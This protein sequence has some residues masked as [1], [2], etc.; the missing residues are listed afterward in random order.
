[1]TLRHFSKKEDKELWLKRRIELLKGIE[2]K[3]IIEMMKKQ[4][5]FSKKSYWYDCR[6][7]VSDIL[8]RKR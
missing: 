7:I 8:K 4:G 2:T 6:G 5:M 3:K 1:M